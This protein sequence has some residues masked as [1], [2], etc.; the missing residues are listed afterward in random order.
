MTEQEQFCYDLC[1]AARRMHIYCRRDDANGQT[2]ITFFDVMAR[3]KIAGKPSQDP[4]EAME[5][6]CRELVRYFIIPTDDS[7]TTAGTP[8]SEGTHD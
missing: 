1:Q 6:A 5:S 3:N 8:P 4:K 7:T 2:T